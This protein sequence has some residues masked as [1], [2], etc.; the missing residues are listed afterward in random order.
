MQA[1]TTTNALPD[2]WSLL[3]QPTAGEIPEP[4]Q[5][6]NQGLVDALKK[7]A[8]SLDGDSIIV[9]IGAEL[10]GSTRL[11]LEH[12]PSAHVVSIDPWPEGYHLPPAWGSLTAAVAKF[13][14]S[15][16]PL[17][18]HY[19]RQYRDRLTAV[20]E[21]SSDGLLKVYAA[22]LKPSLFYVDGDHTYHGVFTDLALINCLFPDIPIF[23]DDWKFTSSYP[24]YR[25][26]EHSVQK[27]AKDFAEH[28][29][30]PL[31]VLSN[32]YVIGARTIEA[33]RY[34]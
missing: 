6:L 1:T 7:H 4:P 26:I 32:T 28:T 12:F 19:C 13:G 18:L 25:G 30:R 33:K 11:F 22:G 20:R 16:L 14:H 31:E 3:P 10:G 27:A 5:R 17:Y 21:F 15:L 9:E 8:P 24:R 2:L 34:A 23:G 29:S